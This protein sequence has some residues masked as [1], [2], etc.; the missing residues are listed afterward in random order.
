MALPSLFISDGNQYFYFLATPFSS[1]AFPP[2]SSR[3]GP[4]YGRISSEKNRV[5]ISLGIGGWLKKRGR[6]SPR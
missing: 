3:A 2:H 1:E 4:E 6:Q 5:G